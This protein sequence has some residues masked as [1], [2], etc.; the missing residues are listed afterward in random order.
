M[1]KNIEVSK[2]S[3]H[4]ANPRKDL[5]D[6]TELAE[7]IKTNG[8]FQN[9]TVVPWFSQT[10]GVGADDPKQQEEMGYIV[11]IGHR[12]LA[13][14]KLAGLTKVPCEISKMSY[15]EQISTMLLE[16]MQRCDLT[17]YEQAQGFQM[18]LD[19]GESV[20]GIAQSTGFSETTVRRRVK[21]LDLDSE[22]FKKSVER[23]GTLMDYLELDK[24]KDVNTKNKIL[25]DI[26]T[27]NFKWNVRQAIDKEKSE[28]NKICIINKLKKF[29]KEVKDSKG[30]TFV[31]GF[32]PSMG[33]K[34]GLLCDSTQFEYFYVI[35]NYGSVD[36]YKKD[37][38][39]ETTKTETKKAEEIARKQREEIRAK[40]WEVTSIAYK[41]RYEFTQNISPAAAKKNID[42]ITQQ[43]L[44]SILD[45]DSIDLED[46]AEF[47]N[48]KV[49]DEADEEE[50]KIN[51]K[52]MQEI[53]AKPEQQ[54]LALAYLTIE[55]KT[56]SYF[57]WQNEFIDNE[58]SNRVY[59]FLEKFGYQMSEEES[60]LRNGTNELF[61]NFD[62]ENFD[63]GN[64]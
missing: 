52:V 6:I 35:T 63:R 61:A 57:N 20:T 5:G 17:I 60:S 58:Y 31:K 53:N 22:K 49:D 8:I 41:L 13:A 15:N 1:I 19:L 30:L 27:D 28:E 7:S 34:I 54:L 33:S 59:D 56:R 39:I 3:P 12:R 18:L 4:Y 9:L 36:L 29:A 38:E 46:F 14:A 32:Q 2:I 47:F 50:E 43:L 26:G 25:K 51:K 10:T 48:V 37:D 21:L 44:Q 64:D 62:N 40:L 55:S 24:I 23:G 16:N 42:V 45:C 11:V